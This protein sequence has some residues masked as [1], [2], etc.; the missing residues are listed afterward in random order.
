M[1]RLHK[2]LFA[3]FVYG[4]L[5]A[6]SFASDTDSLKVA[7]VLDLFRSDQRTELQREF[8]ELF[9]EVDGYQVTGPLAPFHG[10]PPALFGSVRVICPDLES[11]EEAVNK[12]SRQKSLEI[13]DIER[14]VEKP[15]PTGYRG[16]WAR[17]GEPET[18]AFVQI[19]TVQQTRWLIW[20]NDQILK[21]L[22]YSSEAD[23]HSK[24]YAQA[25]SDYLFAIDTGIIYARPPRVTEYGAPDSLDFYAEP[26]DY[27]IEGYQN[28]KNFLRSHRELTTDFATGI[29]AFVPTEET[30]EK[31]KQEA[32][33]KAFPNKE[34]PMLQEE[35]REF[36]ECG[37]DVRVMNTLSREG[38]DTLESGEYFFAVGLSGKI[39]FG[40]ELPREEVERIEEQTGREVPRANHAFLFPGEP[41]LTA[42]AFFID[43]S[44]PGKIVKVN[45]HS[46]HYFYSNVT[47]TVR[48]D[49]SEHS[50]Y[51]LLT[52]GHFFK[53]LDSL[54][55]SYEDILIS[56]L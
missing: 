54:G 55:I 23:E 18:K 52:L 29:V 9:P 27:V 17:V 33:Q 37:G 26:P 8:A 43:N 7:T 32:P 36:F 16:A 35:Y 24:R 6:V 19:N 41:V 2:G 10:K 15:G 42:G 25:V 4:L 45:A 31:L 3:L 13:L 14:W 53:A 40:R 1:T 12:L 46:G 5:V 30:L 47:E 50:D 51:Y 34:A 56:K 39:R 44:A 22:H 28:Y 21:Y 11:F 49:I 48:E 20:A 38:L